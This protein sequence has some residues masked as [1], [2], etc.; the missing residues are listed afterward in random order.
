LVGGRCITIFPFF[1][2]PFILLFSLENVKRRG[3]WS[4]VSRKREALFVFIISGLGGRTRGVRA[5]C[6]ITSR[7]TFPGWKEML[8]GGRFTLYRGSIWKRVWRVSR[9]SPQSPFERALSAFPLP[10][11]W[12]VNGVG[13]I[14]SRGRLR[15]SWNRLL[16][17]PS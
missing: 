2:S 8:T 1:F 17:L 14:Q 5:S 4:V 12:I 7:P 16:I 11:G 9:V 6:S 10:G 13:A 15:P 3:R